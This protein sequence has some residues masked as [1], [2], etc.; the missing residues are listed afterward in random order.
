MFTLA[1]VR[2]WLCRLEGH[3]VGVLEN[4]GCAG[5]SVTVLLGEVF[6]ACNSRGL[7]IAPS[8]GSART[9]IETSS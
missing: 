6:N 5:C 7:V 2:R 4:G 3:S 8:I 9:S 1:R